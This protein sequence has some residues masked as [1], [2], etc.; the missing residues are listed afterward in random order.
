VPVPPIKFH[1]YLP[2]LA[3]CLSHPKEGKQLRAEKRKEEEKHEE[4]QERGGA[5]APKISG[6]VAETYI[7]KRLCG[8][9]FCVAVSCCGDEQA[10]LKA[11]GQRNVPQLL[12]NRCRSREGRIVGEARQGACC[13]IG[14]RR[15]AA[16]AKD[17]FGL[18]L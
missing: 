13:R 11:G 16:I 1:I 6:G 5:S 3:C 18:D 12:G 9:T 8:N 17:A 2:A 10:I 14:C 4:Q 7:Q 15:G